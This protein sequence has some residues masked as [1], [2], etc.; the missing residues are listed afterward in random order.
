MIFS[1]C[2][3]NLYTFTQQLKVAESSLLYVL[4]VKMPTLATM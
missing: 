2:R 3:N 4:A 1:D